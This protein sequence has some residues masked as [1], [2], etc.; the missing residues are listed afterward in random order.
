MTESLLLTEHSIPGGGDGGDVTS[1]KT[2]T[3]ED[4]ANRA[5]VSL[6]TLSDECCQTVL[7]DLAKYCVDWQLVGKRLGL[8]VAD[9]TAVDNDN[10]T[11]DR[12]RVGVLEKWKD[13][14]AFRATYHVLIEALL[15]QGMIQAA[16]EACKVIGAA[17]SRH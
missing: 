9:I 3:I 14:C 10:S 13:R 12:K 17:S 4:V 2:I 7:L 6:D 1:H 15:S 11:E 5:S 16:V 8:T